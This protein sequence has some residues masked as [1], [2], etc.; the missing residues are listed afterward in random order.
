MWLTD[1]KVSQPLILGN[2]HVV[3]AFCFPAILVDSR[4]TITRAA[5]LA[6]FR[7]FGRFGLY[8]LCSNQLCLWKTLRNWAYFKR[9]MKGNQV[10]LAGLVDRED[11]FTSLIR[12][13]WFIRQTNN[14]SAFALSFDLFGNY[15][16]TSAFLVG[17]VVILILS[18]SWYCGQKVAC[19]STI[20]MAATTNRNAKCYVWAWAPPFCR[21]NQVKKVS[22]DTSISN[23]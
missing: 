2:V 14:F 1:N 8:K 19:I 13:S 10:W 18:R 21:I 12:E 15:M 20:A 17:Q 11:H 3:A 7:T 23:R 22:G 16:K 9:K 6:A 5:K 4:Q